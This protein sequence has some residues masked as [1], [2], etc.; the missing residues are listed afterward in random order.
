MLSRT[1]NNPGDINNHLG[2]QTSKTVFMGFICDKE[3]VHQYKNKVISP[4]RQVKI[5]I[6]QYVEG[7]IFI[8]EE[9]QQFPST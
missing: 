8:D 9:G 3:V 2:D 4:I 6:G 7:L 5:Q 1:I